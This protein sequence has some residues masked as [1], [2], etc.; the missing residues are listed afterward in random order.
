MLDNKPATE[1]VDNTLITKTNK[2]D[3]LIVQI[4]LD[5]LKSFCASNFMRLRD[6][7]SMSMMDE[8]NVFLGIQIN[9]GTKELSSHN[10]N[11]QELLKKNL[12][13]TIQRCI[14]VR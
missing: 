2:K 3:L 14:Q 9:K 1:K 13:S 6:M 10:S 4:Y 12:A 8:L 11:R 5:L 7:N